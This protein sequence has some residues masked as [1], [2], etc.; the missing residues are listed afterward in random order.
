MVL[1][2]PQNNPVKQ[3][4]YVYNDP[5]NPENTIG[6]EVRETLL[7]KNYTAL[8]TRLGKLHRDFE[9]NQISEEVFA[10]AF[11]VF[12]DDDLPELKPLLNEWVAK[13]PQSYSALL[14]RSQFL[15]VEGHK[16]RGFDRATN[17]QDEQWQGM[18]TAFQDAYADGL[19]SLQ[20]SEKPTLTYINLM[21]IESTGGTLENIQAHHQSGLE[22]HPNSLLLRR[23]MMLCL[24]PEWQGEG[25]FA[26]MDAFLADPMQRQLPE[27][28]QRQLQA[29]RF[30]AQGHW[31]A[32]FQNKVSEGVTAFQMAVKLH[33]NAWDYDRLGIHC[34][35]L[36][37]Y[38]EAVEAFEESFKRTEDP[39]S[40]L[41]MLIFCRLMVNAG[42][43]RARVLAAQGAANSV[44]GVDELHSALKSPGLFNLG[45]K[46]FL[47]AIENSIQKRLK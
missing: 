23:R 4:F 25:D 3:G 33:P 35:H 32:V 36:K 43:K 44:G 46:S 10:D 11:A 1:P 16:K 37:R 31:L 28:D 17:V 8:E 29:M 2:N 27:S 40:N 26:L 12:T 42:D 13:Y 18:L 9:R 47:A 22:K 5:M 30:S 20:F 19:N 7:A 21:R 14:A 6:I 38:P 39:E 41:F 24:R 45:L 34:M 15:Y